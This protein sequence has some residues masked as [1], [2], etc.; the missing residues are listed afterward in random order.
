MLF[1]KSSLENY[2][3][4]R[5]VKPLIISVLAGWLM[6]GCA[7][8]KPI[9]L[10]PTYLDSNYVK[11]GA[12]PLQE[13]RIEPGD[14]LNITF[15][16]KSVEVTAQLNNYGATKAE[17]ANNSGKIG[18]AAGIEVDV[19][20]NIELPLIGKLKVAGKTRSELKL[21]LTKE[22]GRFLVDPIVYFGE[23][24]K[25]VTVMGQVR[26]PSTQ[27]F[28]DAKASI[29]EA[30]ASAGDVT[31]YAEIEK[32]KVYR[33]VNGVRELGNVNLAD[34]SIF[35]SPYFYL[36][37]NDVLYVPAQSEKLKLAKRNQVLPLVTLG[38]GIVSI[39]LGLSTIFR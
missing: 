3:A 33:D 37:N 4:F 35:S 36:R 16:G 21:I 30:L 27:Q 26:N 7:S 15:A 22:A 11:I 14:F 8:L 19:D 23:L 38:L 24:T 29:F 25:R 12:L 9:D 2:S 13:P 34:S 5:L 17:S 18:G 6:A 32:V 20:G 39:V 28:T 1:F 31:D 10:V